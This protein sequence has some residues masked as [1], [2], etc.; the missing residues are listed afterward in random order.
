MVSK[1]I[2]RSI[3]IKIL[4]TGGWTNTITMAYDVTSSNLLHR[5]TK[6]AVV[7]D[8]DIKGSVPEFISNH[9][10]YSGIKID[11]LP[12]ASLEK[13]LKSHLVVKVDNQLFVMLDTYLFQKRPLNEII[14][15]YVRTNTKDDSDGK[16][17]YGFLLNEIKSM[18]KDREDI[19]DIVVR[20][21]LENEEEKINE[22]SSYLVKKIDE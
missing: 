2:A 8:R 17:F 4:P 20:Y 16:A 6:L 11:F 3:R 21:I 7:L 12:S 14:R 10:Q 9:K 5:G 15:E 13:Y 22:L 18:R 1:N 19:V